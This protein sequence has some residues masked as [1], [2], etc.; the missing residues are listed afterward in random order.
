MKK[1][2]AIP[3]VP[4]LYILNSKLYIITCLYLNL[5]ILA[6]ILYSSWIYICNKAKRKLFHNFLFKW[7]R[8]KKHMLHWKLFHFEIR[9]KHVASSSLIKKFQ[10]QRFVP[11][12]SKFY[13][14]T[15]QSRGVGAIYLIIPP[16][17]TH[18][19]YLL[20]KSVP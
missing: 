6:Y 3:F 11:N 9:K 5:V 14:Q 10:E 2:L 1:S 18:G 20:M 17:Y 8:N 15:L 7:P 19:R 4:C 16:H 12:V 13:N